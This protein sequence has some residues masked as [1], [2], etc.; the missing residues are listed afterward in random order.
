MHGAGNDF[1]AVDNRGG[2]F[3][4]GD[5]AWIRAISGRHTGVG[6]EGV[7]L[8]SGGGDAGVRMHFFNPDGH[9]AEFC[10]NGTRCA[11]LLARDLGMSGSSVVMHT[12]AGTLRAD[13]RAND[14][15]LR[16]P[17]PRDWRMDQSIRLEGK[18]VLFHF[19]NTGVPHAVL[20]VDN[21][22]R[23]DVF[24]LGSA[25]RHHPRFAPHGTNVNFARITG[26]SGLSIRTYERGVEAETGACGSGAVA[27]ALV[28]ARLGLSRL[29]VTVTTSQGHE[30]T[31]DAKPGP[32][33]F[34]EVRLI[35]PA[36]YVFRGVI[37][38]SP[39]G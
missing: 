9:P 12:G 25:M 8:L 17:P 31:V 16:L 18:T 34:D 1:I 5:S 21:L 23:V 27:A 13:V 22:E 10:G 15:S 19:V 38:Y 36:A 32:E 20:A 30:L 2:A 7:I 3:P 11:A 35:G 26:P 6:C 33:G 28:C 37:N 4:A 14:V 29:P 24:S 39:A